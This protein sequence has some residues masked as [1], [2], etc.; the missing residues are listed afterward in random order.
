M[1]STSKLP[2]ALKIFIVSQLAAYESPSAVAK[3]AKEHFKVELSRQAVQ[4]YDPTKVQGRGLSTELR[5]LFEKERTRFNTELDSIGIA[6][7][8]FRLRQLERIFF[9]ALAKDEH[10]LALQCLDRAERATGGNSQPR[11][12]ASNEAQEVIDHRDMSP[13][14]V[15]RRVALIFQDAARMKREAA[16]KTIEHEA[17]NG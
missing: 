9:K 4:A 17:P 3:A 12:E 16:A 15:A 10:F 5:E 11:G 2:A 1:A 7:K 14:A 13:I 8:G 6:Q